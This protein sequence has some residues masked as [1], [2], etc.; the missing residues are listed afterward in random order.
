MKQHLSDIMYHFYPSW[1]KTN[2]M[3]MV[4]S[5]LNSHSNDEIKTALHSEVESAFSVCCQD[6]RFEIFKMLF[7]YIS[8][9]NKIEKTDGGIEI[10]ILRK[11]CY[12]GNERL[13][14]FLI[15]KGADVDA[16]ASDRFASIEMGPLRLST[17]YGYYR[18]CRLLLKFNAKC[19]D[20][21]MLIDML[22]FGTI[23][24]FPTP[25][26]CYDIDYYKTCI[27]L[28][29]TFSQHPETELNGISV[30]DFECNDLKYE[31]SQSKDI[32][33]L[34]IM[35]RRCYNIKNMLFVVRIRC[36]VR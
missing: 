7:P 22:T 20:K 27:C 24:I 10:A 4:A 21:T 16:T 17:R 32:R 14:K 9:I 33:R 34:L 8:D 36:F 2:N 6:G 19:N 28:L 13:C 29:Q 1:I 5:Y 26:F 31:T 35:W 15:K 30:F 23:P 12:S 25:A 18:I 3:E 11:A